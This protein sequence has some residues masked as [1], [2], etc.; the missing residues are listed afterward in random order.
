[1]I[2]ISDKFLS[3]Q[4]TVI[5]KPALL[6]AALRRVHPVRQ[7]GAARPVLVVVDRQRAVRNLRA[8]RGRIGS[9]LQRAVA[10]DAHDAAHAV[11][12]VRRDHGVAVAVAQERR[13]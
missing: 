11:G 6:R 3:L 2:V 9:C 13:A 4:L 10:A 12:A 1:M 5:S 7:V 8:R